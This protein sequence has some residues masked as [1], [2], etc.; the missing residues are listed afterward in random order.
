MFST[1]HIKHIVINLFY[2]VI[3]AF[4]HISVEP[5]LRKGSSLSQKWKDK[6]V[7]SSLKIKAKLVDKEIKVKKYK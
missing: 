7:S 6:K 5:Q 1:S 4:V 2:E 3:V